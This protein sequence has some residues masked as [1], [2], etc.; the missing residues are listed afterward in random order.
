MHKAC[1]KVSKAQSSGLK[2]NTQGIF[3]N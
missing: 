1:A 3:S 2:F